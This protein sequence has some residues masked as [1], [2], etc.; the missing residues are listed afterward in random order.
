MSC[1]KLNDSGQNVTRQSD[2]HCS[3]LNPRCKFELLI[4]IIP[5]VLHELKLQTIIPKMFRKSLADTGSH[6]FANFSNYF[7]WLKTGGTGYKIQS[8]KYRPSIS[9]VKRNH[10]TVCDFVLIL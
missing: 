3:D 1:T 6:F 7:D 5:I 2:N 9:L 4:A 10:L 8:F